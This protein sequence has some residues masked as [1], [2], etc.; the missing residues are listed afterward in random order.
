MSATIFQ[1][2]IK[3]SKG[4]KIPLYTE[5]EILTT[6]QALNCFGSSSIRKTEKD[7]DDI[8]PLEVMKAL[9]EAKSSEFVSS[10]SKTIITKI[11][12]SIE[13]L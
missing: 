10:K 5:E 6:L 2:P 13:I 12:K 3:S 9:Y 8:E 7:L 1:F 4:L 11:L